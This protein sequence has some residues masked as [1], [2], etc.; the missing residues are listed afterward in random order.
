MFTAVSID[1]KA[2]GSDDGFGD[3]AQVQVRNSRGRWEE[4]GGGGGRE[5]R[6]AESAHVK[7]WGLMPAGGP[8][9][10]LSIFLY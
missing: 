2:G 9:C 3:A 1:S 4:G 5:E 7:H 10:P 8:N 6:W